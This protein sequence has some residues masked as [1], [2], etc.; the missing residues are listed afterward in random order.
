[1]PK[2]IYFPQ[3]EK[4]FSNIDEAERKRY[5]FF[6][7]DKSEITYQ[8]QK[9]TYNF[10]D[11]KEKTRL[12]VYFDLLEKYRYPMATIEFDAEVNGCQADIVVYADVSRKKVHLIVEC[13]GEANL[14]KEIKKAAVKA[15][16]MRAIYASVVT[17]GGRQTVK[18]G[19][20]KTTVV[21][22]IPVCDGSN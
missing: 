2:Q 13:F 22:D 7:R 21:P 1:M 4:M 20:I 9:R 10:R 17:T 5:V 15:R 19:K 8:P 3:E 18:L 14:A 16:T 6:N 12:N 11:P